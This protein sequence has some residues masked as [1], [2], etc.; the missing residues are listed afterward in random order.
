MTERQ[1]QPPP[2]SKAEISATLL[3]CRWALDR[4]VANQ[5]YGGRRDGESVVTSE[6]CLRLDQISREILEVGSAISAGDTP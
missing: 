1:Q 2:M 6:Q 3:R 5:A 4:I